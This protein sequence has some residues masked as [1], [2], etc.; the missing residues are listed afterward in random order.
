ME[1][2]EELE[3]KGVSQLMAE[4]FARGVPTG[5]FCKAV[6]A[7]S[8]TTSR[9][10]IANSFADEAAYQEQVLHETGLDGGGYYPTAEDAGDAEFD[11]RMNDPFTAVLAA[12]DNK[13]AIEK[14]GEADEENMER[15]QGGR[16]SEP[17][18]LTGGQKSYGPG[19]NYFIEFIKPYMGD[20]KSGKISYKDAI[21]NARNDFDNYMSLGMGAFSSP[22]DLYN[23]IHGPGGV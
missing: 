6:P 2:R 18:G 8:K 11:R 9:E 16:V 3:T 23:Y 1:S 14:D 22:E 12:Q 15:L 20:I 19:V 7:R 17:A 5:A 4:R 13:K 10:D 21:T